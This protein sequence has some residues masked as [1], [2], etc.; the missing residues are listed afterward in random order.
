MARQKLRRIACDRSMSRTSLTGSGSGFEE[1][2]AAATAPVVA[3]FHCDWKICEVGLKGRGIGGPLIERWVRGDLSIPRMMNGKHR[4]GLDTRN[5]TLSPMKQP[6]G[7]KS[8]EALLGQLGGR[9]LP[10]MDL[11]RRSRRI[12]LKMPRWRRFGFISS[13]K[14]M[15]TPVNFRAPSR[16]FAHSGEK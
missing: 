12:S 5:T 11:T 7:R 3:N 9:Q 15:K 1:D 2:R 10:S 6:I 8:F 16:M 14:H 4:Y 13:G